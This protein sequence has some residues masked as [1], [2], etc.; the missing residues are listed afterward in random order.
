MTDEPMTDQHFRPRNGKILG[1]VLWVV[2]AAGLIVPLITRFSLTDVLLALPIVGLLAFCGY[3]LFWYPEVVVGS[4]SVTLVNPVRTIEVP[5]EAL[6]TVDTK[7]ALTLVTP[8]GRFS[9]WAAPAPG[10]V[11]TYR[12]KP[13]DA[14]GLPSTTYGAQG[15]L[16]PG[17]LKRSDSGA[18]A[19]LVR[20]RWA[21][22]AEAGALDVDHTENAVVSRQVH[23]PLVGIAGVLV[24]AVIVLGA[25][26]F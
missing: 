1:V 17:D 15:S 12:S 19:Y 21:A 8:V 18:A 26:S 3:W 6:I 7:F 11:T 14:Q 22:L 16:R 13:G 9:A 24:A 25:L 20:S 4:D 2:A 23:W 5:W 10:V